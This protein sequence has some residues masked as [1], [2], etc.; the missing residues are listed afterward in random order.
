MSQRQ[1]LDVACR[2]IVCDSSLH[3]IIMGLCVIE[4]LKLQ[5]V[6]RCYKWRLFTGKTGFLSWWRRMSSIF[7]AFLSWVLHPIQTQQ[8]VTEWFV[9]KPAVRRWLHQACGHKIQKSVRWRLWLLFVL[10]N[11]S[12]QCFC[13]EWMN[14]NCQKIELVLSK[15]NCWRI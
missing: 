3:N 8:I 13:D 9:M 6:K 5:S 11:E 15:P 2:P 1:H 12:V 4:R 7:N 14:Q 10:I